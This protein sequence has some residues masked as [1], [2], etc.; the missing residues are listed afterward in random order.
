MPVPS[1]MEFRR[2]AGRFPRVMLALQTCCAGYANAVLTPNVVEFKRLADVLGVDAESD[3][4]LTD[5]AAALGGPVVV[6]KGR[7]A[8]RDPLLVPASGV[9]V[10]LR[11]CLMSAPHEE[12]PS[13][14]F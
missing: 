13:I 1:V 12:R 2:L 14:F 4:A 8:A 10:S 6:R 9:S 5:V 3:S 11:M 7:H